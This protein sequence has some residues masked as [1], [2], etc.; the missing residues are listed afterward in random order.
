WVAVDTFAGMTKLPT[1]LWARPRRA[2]NK[3]GAS[4]AKP[5]A[6]VLAQGQTLYREPL[7]RLLAEHEDHAPPSLLLLGL[8]DEAKAIRSHAVDALSRLSPSTT[9]QSKPLLGEVLALLSS[10]NAGTRMAVAELLAVWGEP[11]ARQ[12]LSEIYETERRAA[13]RVYLE[14]ALVAVGAFDVLLPDA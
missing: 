7:Y 5:V 4:L 8:S 10:E 2:L 14:E 6:F 9:S 1:S 11:A 3:L 13:V 12:T